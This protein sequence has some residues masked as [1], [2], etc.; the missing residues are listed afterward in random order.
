MKTI[1]TI[2]LLA[3][4]AS[5]AGCAVGPDYHR[6]APTPNQPLAGT[7]SDDSTNQVVWKIA[8][9]SANLPRGEWWQIF[10]DAELNRL[11]TLASDE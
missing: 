6:P 5:L 4:A 11:E 7:F 9:P 10:N 1:F 3:L 8:E 2:T